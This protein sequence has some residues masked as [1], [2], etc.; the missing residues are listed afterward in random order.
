MQPSKENETSI[1]QDNEQEESTTLHNPFNPDDER[2]FS[3]EDLENEQKYK[4]AL[5]ERD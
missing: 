1:E 4:E 5:T 3:T 2:T